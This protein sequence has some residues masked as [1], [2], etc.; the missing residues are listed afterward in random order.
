MLRNRAGVGN[1]QVDEGPRDSLFS[2]LHQLLPYIVIANI[3]ILPIALFVVCKSIL[4][5]R[6][7]STVLLIAAFCMS[8]YFTYSRKYQ[9]GE[10]L[11]HPLSYLFV[12]IFRRFWLNEWRGWS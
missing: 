6:Q 12:S 11:P 1:W 7:L 8:Y 2:K 5:V 3:I 4:T 10:Q 9:V